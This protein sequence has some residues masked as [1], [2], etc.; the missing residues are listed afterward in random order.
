[1]SF[2]SS[3]A[4]ALA[5][6]AFTLSG[7]WAQSPA[8]EAADKQ[9]LLPLEVSING[10]QGG[11]WTL[12]ERGGTLYAP[13]DAFEEWRVNRLRSV[14]PVTHLGQLWYPLASV[15][16]FSSKMNF[17]N[18]SVDV[19]FAPNA[20]AAT[21]LGSESAERPSVTPAEPALFLNFDLSLTQASARSA[22]TTRDLGA[23]TELGFTSRWGL[24]TSSFVARNLTGGDPATT[25]SVRRLETTFTHD[26]PESDVSLRLGDSTTRTGSWGRSVYFGGL[27]IGRNFG[28]K[29][30]FI[31]QPIPIVSG[32]SSAPSTVELYIND[33]LRQTS[34]VPT[35]PFA[36]DNFPLLTGSGQARMVVRD[37]LGRETVLVQDFFSH[38]SLLENGLS[39]W[40]VEAGAV[41]QNLSIFNADYGQR[42]M[43][44][45]WRQGLSQGLTLE[46]R[47]EATRQTL[48][49]GLGMTAALPGQLLGQLASAFSRDAAAGQGHQ[50]L[51]GLEYSSLNHGFTL[52]S[53]NASRSYRQIGQENGTPPYR[54]QWSGSYTY[55][56]EH[57]GSI[58][59]GYARIDSYD[60]RPLTTY[61]ANY[62]IRV[63]Q[64]SSLTFN[65][66]RVADAD[67]F[68]SGTSAGVSLLIPLDRQLTMSSSLSHRTAQTDGYV[69]ASQGLTGET[70]LGWR[71]LAGQ[72]TG[73]NYAEGGLYHQG[74]KGLFTADLN[75]SARQ[76]TLRLG[77]QG[78]LV[79]IDGQVFGSRLVENSFAL[80]EVPGY[81]NVGVSSQGR[82]TAR[83]DGDGKTLITGL[84]PYQSN[85]IRLDPSELP[86][87][88][89]IDSIEQM[90]VPAAR[91]GV[92]IRF[93]VRSGRGA[94]IKIVLDDGEPAPAGAEIELMGDKQ[95]FFV[96]R[97]GEAFITGLQTTNRLRLKWD[98]ASCTFAVALPPASSQD[99]IARVGP[100]KC[101]GVKR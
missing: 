86:I 4:M 68:G 23:L 18:Q 66:V 72:R 39:D 25:R 10:A 53:E 5:I 32:V 89:E 91:S 96:A 13:S 14:N 94:L 35:G 92:V 24:L 15:P 26:F 75:A 34:Q 46:A 28:L 22:A 87:S 99:D 52:R 51:M 69:S 82:M 76:Q 81:A 42:F 54:R 43:S 97:R 20:F 21:R 30:G 67:G 83:T 100:L 19:I 85:S 98:G 70:G 41:R 50:W 59:L 44:G 55:A 27:Q 11:N 47:G 95:E 74:N 88:A 37:V 38:S 17:S 16:G 8:L 71:A 56:S 12:L 79:M 80:V 73:E 49:A 45:L 33:A 84:L 77:A 2:L 63:G 101:S 40:S 3:A 1:M 61:S 29:P 7:A 36:I 9:R 65:V 48:G 57:F 93:P 62:S 64:R 58:G 78:G 6:M 90:A 60:R 31:T